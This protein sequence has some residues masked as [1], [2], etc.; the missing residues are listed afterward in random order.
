VSPSSLAEPRVNFKDVLSEL[1]HGPG[2]VDFRSG[3][4][5]WWDGHGDDGQ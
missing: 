3:L 1:I 5:L 2:G 4:S